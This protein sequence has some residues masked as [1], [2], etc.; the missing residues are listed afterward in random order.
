[1]KFT[2]QEAIKDIE[3]ANKIIQKRT[4]YSCGLIPVE[5]I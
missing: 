5:G 1:M 2:K 4:R 3:K